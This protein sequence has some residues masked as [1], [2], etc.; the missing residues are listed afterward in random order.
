[1]EWEDKL[2]LNPGEVL[3]EESH[4]MKG[5]LQETDI[6]TYSIQ[7]AAGE[8]VGSVVRTDHTAIRGFARTQSVEQRDSTGTVIVDLRW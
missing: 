7:N 6:Y 8:N 2:I 1:M 3:V 4:R 5:S